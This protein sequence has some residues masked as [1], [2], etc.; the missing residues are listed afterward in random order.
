MSSTIASQDRGEF[1]DSDATFRDFW[2]IFRSALKRNDVSTIAGMTK[3]PMEG[4]LASNPDFAEIDTQE[5]FRQHFDKLF[6]KDA[7]RTLLTTTPE[8]NG[9]YSDTRGIPN[10]WSISHK[11][12]TSLGDG[13]WT[14]SA[15]IY[16]FTR[17]GDGLI[18]LTHISIAG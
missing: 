8:S 14:D 2:G 11:T 10:S 13:E 1:H 7:I 4:E 16:R 3:F 5:G 12:T 9:T 18:K 17:L 6:P 15:V